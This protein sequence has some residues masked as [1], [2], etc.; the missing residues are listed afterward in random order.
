VLV[1][2]VMAMAVAVAVLTTLEE[3]VLAV[4]MGVEV[5]LA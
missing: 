5:V 1:V 3:V 4:P 2:A